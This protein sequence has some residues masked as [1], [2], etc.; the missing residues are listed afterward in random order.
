M[1]NIINIGMAELNTS[2]HPGILVTQGLGSCVGIAMYDVKTK[3]IGL[4]HIM[5][6]LSP[7]SSSNINAAKYADTAIN[8]ML[9]DMNRLGASIENITAKLAGGA[10]MF[11]FNETSELMR[12]G[13]RNVI[14][15]KEK[16][17]ELGILVVAEDTG[18]NL[19][20]TIEFYSEN[21]GLMVKTLGIGTKWI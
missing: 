13:E 9:H 3:A 11:N 5:L 20:R 17:S 15:A 8:K 16:L 21:G 12:I 7:N 4:A 14:A 18:G 19:V 1:S 2:K 10:Q 6:P